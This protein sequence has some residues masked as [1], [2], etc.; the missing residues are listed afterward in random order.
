MIRI[1]LAALAFALAACS[2]PASDTA[3]ETSVA[4]AE[5]A[6]VTTAACTVEAPARDITLGGA[7]YKAEA[8]AEGDTCD[9]ARAE[10]RLRAPNGNAIFETAYPTN[11]IPLAF[12]VTG[13]DQTRLA[14]ELAG[15]TENVAQQPTADGLP[16]WPQGADKPPHFTATVARDAYEAA[17]TA[18]RPL[19][20]FP[21]GNE[22]NACVG[23]DTSTQTAT[24]LGSWTP[25]RP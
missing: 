8:R 25:G 15:W 13:S 21:D 24:L 16:A 9:A 5:T 23:V 10:L 2:P 19:F 3:S 17:R 12:N 4:P 7:T 6:S 20:C 14:T 18:R 1:S 11:Q 22:S